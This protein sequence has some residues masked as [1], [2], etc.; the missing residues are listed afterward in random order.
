MRVNRLKLIV[1]MGLLL[2]TATGL[3]GCPDSEVIV[4]FPD[5]SLEA[6]V[7]DALRKPF[8]LITAADL[9][10]LRTLPSDR[11]ARLGVR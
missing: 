8:G 4:I 7:R 11:D 3:V 2:T 9:V 6:A 5:D 1:C 10:D